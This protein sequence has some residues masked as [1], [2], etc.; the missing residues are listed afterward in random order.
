MPLPN[1]IG[2]V[3]VGLADLDRVAPLFDRY[4]QFY[5]QKSDLTAAYAF[6]SQRIGRNESVVFLAVG[7]PPES[8]ALGFTQLYPS[9]TSEAMAPLWILN[10]LFVSESARRHGVAKALMERAQ[11]HALETGAERLVLETAVDNIAA[12]SLYKKMGW[13]RDTEFH[14]YYLKL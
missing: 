4:R 12:Q 3:R 14:R 2:T 11:Q 5:G 8:A 10:D 13:K 1:E 7:P 9:F 6:L